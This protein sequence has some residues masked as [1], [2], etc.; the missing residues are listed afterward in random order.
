MASRLERAGVQ[1]VYGFM[2][3]K[4][5][6]KVSMVVRREGAMFRTYCH[7]GTGN[8]HP[9]TARIYTD[10]SFFT[11][12][13]RAARD[14]G[15]LFNFISG[16]VAPRNLELITLS[17]R[18]LREKLAALINAEISNAKAGKPA[19]IWAKMNSLVDPQIIDRLYA[20][21]EAGVSIDLI[22]RGIC[23]LRPGVPGMS[24]NIR[25]KSIVGRFL[26]HSRIWVFAN[27]ARL[28]HRKMSALTVLCQPPCPGQEF[29]SDTKNI[30]SG[31][32]AKLRMFNETLKSAFPKIPE[33][34]VLQLV[35]IS[36]AR[37]AITQATCRDVLEISRRNNQRNSVTGLLVA[38]KRRFLQA[39]EGPADAVRATY[40]RILADPRHYA[41]VLL[42]EHYLDTRHFGNWAM[43]YTL[44]GSDLCDEEELAAIV[45][46]LVDPV[47]DASMRAQFLGFADLQVA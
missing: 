40:A 3:L 43:G 30:C 9:V 36:S 6:A 26:E 35:Y 17:P 21:S 15:K 33:N 5:H 44:G 16:Y 28:P 25:V 38:G 14:A 39:I 12:S 11:A 47:T 32:G 19:A 24:S 18:G 2:D 46:S 29:A 42:S 31:S 27:G 34:L 45:T 22:I 41:C 10:L 37:E 4:T 13:R 1:V 23:C 8:Y 20:A 7:F